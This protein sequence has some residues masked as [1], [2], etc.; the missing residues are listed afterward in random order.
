MPDSLG[1]GALPFACRA[2]SSH[3]KILHGKRQRATNP[4]MGDERLLSTPHARARP[5]CGYTLAS[6]AHFV[7][8]RFRVGRGR[9]VRTVTTKDEA[10]PNSLC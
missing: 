10:Q 7:S 6:L 9:G 3:K 8:R 2:C 1:I 5:V 4:P